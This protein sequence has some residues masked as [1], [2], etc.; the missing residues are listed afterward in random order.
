MPDSTESKL[1]GF[2]EN[3]TPTPAVPT[4]ETLKTDANAILHEAKSLASDV[5]LEAK[6]QASNL[7]DQAKAQVAQTA[8]KVKGMAAEQKDLLAGHIGGLAA[9]MSRVADDLDQNNDASAHYA[10]LIADNAEKLSTTIH[11]NDVDQIL[12]IAQNFGRKQPAAFM[13]AAALLGFAASRFLMASAKRTTT[14]TP[15]SVTTQASYAP[16]VGSVRAVPGENSYTPR[17]A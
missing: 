4:P 12:E 15:S 11:D 1:T 2:S 10:R 5:A 9:S 6:D 7:A 16:S 3:S 17:S 14:A 8:E 13:G